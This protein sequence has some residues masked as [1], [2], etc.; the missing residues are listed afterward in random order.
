MSLPLEIRNTLAFRKVV[1][2]ANQT[3]FSTITTKFWNVHSP[4]Y[5]PENFDHVQVG[6]S[7]AL[8]CGTI[9]LMDLINSIH[10]KSEQTI[11]IDKQPTQ[12][13]VEAVLEGATH[14]N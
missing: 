6:I 11:F 9:N 8:L 10:T 13:F 1:R 4:S 3:A 2:V 5:M 12:A 14:A 7:K